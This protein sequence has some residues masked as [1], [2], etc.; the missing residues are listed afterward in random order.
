MKKKHISDC[1]ILIMEDEQ[2][3]KGIYEREM[4]NSFA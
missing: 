3:K 1:F 4:M 2:Q